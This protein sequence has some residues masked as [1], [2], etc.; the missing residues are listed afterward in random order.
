METSVSRILESSS[1]NKGGVD[2]NA[3]QISIWTTLAEQLLNLG[4]KNQ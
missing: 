3:L 4:Y 2:G 1:L